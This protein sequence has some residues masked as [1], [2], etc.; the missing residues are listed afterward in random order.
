MPQV[1]IVDDDANLRELVRYVLKKDGLET[2]EAADG[3]VALEI[4]ASERAD[5]VVLDIMMPRLDGWDLC[6]RVKREWDI[7][8]LMLSAKGQAEDKVRGLDLGADDYLAKPFDTDELRARVRAL[9]RRYRLDGSK[10]LKV[11]RVVL[12]RDGREAILG[13]ERIALPLKEFELLLKLGAR[14]GTAFTRDAIISDLWERDYDG[15]DRTVDVHVN[16][17]RERFPEER[18]GFRITALRGIGYRLDLTP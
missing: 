10:K 15:T 13:D 4:L 14:P 16:R 5:C 12:D 2:A 6:R 18:S 9:L 8:V 1:L 3:R 7:P 17:L 11:G